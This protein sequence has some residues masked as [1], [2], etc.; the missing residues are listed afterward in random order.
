MTSHGTLSNYSTSVTDQSY[1]WLSRITSLTI[2]NCEWFSWS[3]CNECSM[4]LLLF[5]I[6]CSVPVWDLHILYLL[7]PIVILP[8]L[9][10]GYPL[11]ILSRL[12]YDYTTVVWHENVAVNTTVT[13]D[14]WIT[15]VIV[16]N[17]PQSVY[18]CYVFQVIERS[19][20]FVL[21]LSFFFTLSILFFQHSL[22]C[23]VF[24]YRFSCLF[25]KF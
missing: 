4:S 3:I 7:K 20:Y 15:L 9:H 12:S 6:H 18:H 14:Y 13:R 19:L 1:L 5:R 17:Y 8:T 2:L 22:W 10:L 25:K 21:S 11:T 23:Q 24:R 16:I